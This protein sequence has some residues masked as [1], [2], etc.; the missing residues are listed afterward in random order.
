MQFPDSFPHVTTTPQGPSGGHRARHSTD[1]RDTAAAAKAMDEVAKAWSIL[2]N[3]L[4]GREFVL[5]DQP[6]LADIPVGCA[7]YRWSSMDIERP[8]LPNLEAWYAR[9]SSRPAYA[10]NVMLPIT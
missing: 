4:E 1:S 6:S 5:G 3:Q 10:A 7:V 8:S 2:N 9:L